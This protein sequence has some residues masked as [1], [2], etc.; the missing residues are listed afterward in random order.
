MREVNLT[1]WAQLEG[2]EYKGFLP[3]WWDA[4]QK[5]DPYPREVVLVIHERHRKFVQEVTGDGTKVIALNEPYSMK[6][7]VTALE[8]A[9]SE[10]VGFCGIDDRMYPNAYHDLADH[11]GEGEIMVGTLELSTGQTWHGSWNIEDLKRANTL[12]A[13][14]PH[15][16]S[17]YNRLGGYPEIR[18]WDW[19]FWLKS[20]K[21]GVEVFHS[22][23]P[24]AWFDVGTDRQTIGGLSLDEEVR[25]RA[26]AE[27][28]A[29]VRELW[30][31]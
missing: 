12:P 14:S 18:W 9:T 11:N 24:I 7:V 31:D 21:A 26:D 5:M 30:G 8:N 6:Y 15:R 3:D 4:V 27:I 28:H 10:W 22:S 23:I 1:L 29:L 25:A 13:L 19:G 17:L 2:E 20:A 16:K